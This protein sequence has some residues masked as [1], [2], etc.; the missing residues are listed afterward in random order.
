[1]WVDP[2]G[3]MPPVTLGQAR[4]EHEDLALAANRDY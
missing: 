1:M 4:D 3:V 2:L